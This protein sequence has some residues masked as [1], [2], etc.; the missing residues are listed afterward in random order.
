MPDSSR[1]STNKIFITVLVLL[2]LGSFYLLSS[3]LTPFLAGALI[4]YLCDPLVRRLMKFRIKRIY[5]VLI[6]FST[7]FIGTLFFLLMLIPLIERQIVALLTQLPDTIAWLMAKA[8]WTLAYYNVSFNPQDATIKQ[9]FAEYITKA[10]GFANWALQTTLR[11]GKAIFQTIVFMILIPIVTF[12]LLRDWPIFLASLEKIL[13]KK[14]KP[15]IISIAQECDEVIGAFFRGQL[16][17]MLALGIYY[18]AGLTALGLNVGVVVGLIIGVIS[19][20]PY[21]GSIVGVFI[22]A[23]VTYA[24]FNDIKH[25]MWLALIFI[26]GHILENF[27]LSPYLIGNRVGLHPVL[28]IFAILAGGTLFGLFGVLL[29]IPSA[30]IIMILLRHLFKPYHMAVDNLG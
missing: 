24:Q 20:I 4:A 6:V 26:I 7:V 21:L 23:L 17:V 3:V 9:L 18:S 28:V 2:V 27:V 29:A 5:A 19:I 22:A 12:Y 13:P 25:L 11:S 10:G 30:A 1:Q 15:K 16:L 8:K 14:I